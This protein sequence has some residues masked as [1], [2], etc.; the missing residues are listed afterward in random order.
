MLSRNVYIQ[1]C[2]M[3]LFK[4]LSCSTK[5]RVFWTISSYLRVSTEH[6]LFYPVTPS[7]LPSNLQVIRHVS[8]EKRLLGLT[9]S[10]WVLLGLA[11]SYWVLLGTPEVQYLRAQSIR[12]RKRGHTREYRAIRNTRTAKLLR[13]CIPHLRFTQQMTLGMFLLGI[14]PSMT[15]QHPPTEVGVAGCRVTQQIV[16]Q[17]CFYWALYPARPSKTQ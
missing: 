10:Y 5:I 16:T 9:G 12:A 3:Y 15:Q 2:T 14:L 6:P 1:W 13:A 4:G 11:G 17:N 8:T 7:I